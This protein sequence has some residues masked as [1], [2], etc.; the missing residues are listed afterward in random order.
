MF[1]FN[2]EIGIP[3]VGRNAISSAEL[4]DMSKSLLLRMAFTVWY[5][6]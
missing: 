1:K 5:V 2:C 6:F 4:I 3:N